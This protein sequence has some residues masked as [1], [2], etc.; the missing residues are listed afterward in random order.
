MGRPATGWKPYNNEYHN[1]KARSKRRGIDFEFSYDEWIEWWGADITKRG[2]K[3]G[4]MVMARNGDVGPYCLTNV[5]KATVEGNVKERFIGPGEQ[6]RIISLKQTCEN[7]KKIKE[8]Q[9]CL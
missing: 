9:I 2:R 6:K 4:Q 7:R 5:H 8:T 3:V 1:H